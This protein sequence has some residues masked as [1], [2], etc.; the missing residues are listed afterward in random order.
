MTA[1]YH[2]RSP[3]T[4]QLRTR[5]IDLTLAAILGAAL[6]LTALGWYGRLSP[7]QAM[8]QSAPQGSAGKPLVP[9]EP[10]TIPAQA[11]P[12]RANASLFRD[13]G[14]RPPLFRRD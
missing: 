9:A 10:A 11:P 3:A 1:P 2:T 12:P 6:V 8:V 14:P 7:P 4:I 13:P 5:L